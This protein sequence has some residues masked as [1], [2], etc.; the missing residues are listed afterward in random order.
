MKKAML[1]TALL[2]LSLLITAKAAFSADW[3][4]QNPLPQ[5]HTLNDVW[6]SSG[7]DV[8]AVGTCG[9]ILHYDGQSWTVMN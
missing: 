3:E 4:W 8:F 1:T 7:T 2:F 9:T 5:G 6:G